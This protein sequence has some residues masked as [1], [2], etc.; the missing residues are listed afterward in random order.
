[1]WTGSLP[2]TVRHRASVAG[3]LGE[4]LLRGF[5]RIVVTLGHGWPRGFPSIVGNLR[6]LSQYLVFLEDEF[7]LHG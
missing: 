5:R 2:I 6:E 3:T 1:M 7:V 4:E